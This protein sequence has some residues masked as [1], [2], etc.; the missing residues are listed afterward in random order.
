MTSYAFFLRNGD[1]HEAHADTIEDA[2]REVCKR[3]GRSWSD[4]ALDVI[5]VLGPDP[6]ALQRKVARAASQ[7]AGNRRM[8]RAGRNVWNLSDYRHAARTYSRL[9]ASARTTPPPAAS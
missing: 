2:F 3:V 9:M 6:G 4:L 8:Q 5:E 1:I 7:D